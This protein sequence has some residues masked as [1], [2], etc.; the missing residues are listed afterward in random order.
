[1][2]A[3]RQLLGTNYRGVVA[4]AAEWREL[5]ETLGLPKVPHH[6]TPARAAPRLLAGAEKGGRSS[7]PGLG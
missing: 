6:P 4:L 5:R 2:L 7:A 1:L 3:L